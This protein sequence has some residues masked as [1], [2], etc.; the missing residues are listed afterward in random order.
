MKFSVKKMMKMMW[1]RMKTRI[2]R[3]IYRKG[4]LWGVVV[5]E[6]VI[7]WMQKDVKIQ[8]MD[9]DSGKM[10]RKSCLKRHLINRGS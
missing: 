10:M 6:V 9:R 5:A 8:R 7:Y 1:R 2:L 4:K 3:D